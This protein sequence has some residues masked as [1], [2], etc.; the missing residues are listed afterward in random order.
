MECASCSTIFF[1]RGVTLSIRRSAFSTSFFLIC[2]AC[3]RNFIIVG[4]T[5][6]ESNQKKK[7]STSSSTICRA[8]TASF[9]RPSKFCVTTFCISSI[10]Y[11]KTLSSSATA[12]SIS[13]GTAISMKSSGFVRWL[14]NKA[15]SF[16]S[17]IYLGDAVQLITISASLK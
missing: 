16:F 15:M 14:T 12:G 10:S 7:F 13:R 5:R 1:S 8:F 17:I 9:C 2:S 3:S 6:R 11:K 4:T